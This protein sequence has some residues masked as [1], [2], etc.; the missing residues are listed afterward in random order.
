MS[1]STSRPDAAL[2]SRSASS[3]S[4][5]SMNWRL[6]RPL[7][8]S[9]LRQQ[10]GCSFV[11]FGEALGA[12]H[13]EGENGGCLDRIDEAIEGSQ[14]GLDAVEVVRLIEPL[15]IPSNSLVDG[16]GEPETGPPQCSRR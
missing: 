14:C 12:G 15:V 9:V 10:E 5:G 1:A 11:A 2:T 8:S 7:L 6:S 13:T 3:R 4:S 16:D